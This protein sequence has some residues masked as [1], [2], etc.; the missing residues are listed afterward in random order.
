MLDI[1]LIRQD[2]DGVNKALKRRSPDLSVDT[3]LML[4]QKRIQLLQEEEILRSDR[5]R[6]SKEVGQ[7]KSKGENADALQDETR[8]IGERIKIIEAEKDALALEQDNLLAV[9]PNI[10]FAEVPEGRDETANVVVRTWGEEF[11]TR[12]VNNP[13]PHWEIATSLGM[14]DFERGVKVAQSRFLCLTGQGAKL[15]RAL[16]DLMLSLHTQKSYRE[17]M[18]PFLVNAQAMYGTGQLPKFAS[19]MFACRDD[20]LYLA[21]TAEVPVTNLYA[22]EILDESDLPIHMAAYTPCFRREAGSAGRDTRGMMRLHQFNKVELVKLVAPE[23]SRD[24]HEALLRDAEAVLQLLELPYRVV[25][26]CTGDIGFSAAK[27]YDIEVWFPSQACYREISSCSNF[28]DFQARRANIKFRS[29][30]SDK[31]QFVHTL[32]GSGL[33]VGRTMAAILENY[34]V[35]EN[36]VFIPQA[37]QS[38]FSQQTEFTYD[39]SRT[40]A[41]RV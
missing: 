28:G 36:R 23:T 9:L 20:E 7:L 38:Y 14:V 15:E 26:L 5:N 6:L 24:A 16:I 10:P 1:R 30:N 34:Q 40:T 18:P 21:P 39:G 3:I 11:K 31:P 33:A 12:P 2:P 32:N 35:S 13:L 25:E 41:V 17:V 19:D 37:L 4:D 27:C 22:G 29:A 8:A